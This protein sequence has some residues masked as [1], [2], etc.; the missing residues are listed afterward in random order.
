MRSHHL[1]FGEVKRQSLPDILGLLSNIHW[2][3][4]WNTI[5]QLDMNLSR[6]EH[7]WNEVQVRTS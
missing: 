7:C 1:S 5:Q 6:L 4:L 2:A 3:D